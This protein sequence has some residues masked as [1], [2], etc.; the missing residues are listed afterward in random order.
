[1]NTTRRLFIQGALA[2]AITVALAPLGQAQSAVSKRAARSAPKAAAPAA[3]KDSG[4]TAKTIVY[5]PKDIVAVNTQ[6]RFTTLIIL[7]TDEEILDFVCGDAG[8]W[9]IRGEQNFAYVKPATE[10]SKSNLNLVTAAGTVYSFLL[11][12]ISGEKGGRPD[13]KVFVEAG[14]AK[15]QVTPAPSKRL[16]SSKELDD[17]RAQVELAKAAA[18]K[19][20]E[21]SR[22]AIDAGIS[23]FV[24]NVRFA[25]RFEAGKKPF[26]VRAMYHDEKFTY[27]RARPEE[28]PTLY[29][30]KDNRPNLV[31]F[32][33]ASGVY[34]V[35]KVLDSGY[36]VIGRKR[37]AFKRED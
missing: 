20:R 10:G 15:G 31:S 23:D 22:E 36:F 29:E 19:V 7:P 14:S 24:S 32:D 37:L 13:L 25:Y 17:A 34:T 35:S 8:L 9:D 16:V 18:E 4:P 6:V 3:P 33:Y 21:E 27:I 12:E 30:L 1:M 26:N 5:S 11:N 2:L 28:T